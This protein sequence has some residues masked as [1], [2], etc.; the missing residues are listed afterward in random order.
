MDPSTR[1][2]LAQHCGASARTCER[3]QSLWSGYGAIWRCTLTDGRSVVLKSVQPPAGG[4]ISHRRK[5]RSYAVECRWYADFAPECDSA[6]RVPQVLALDPTPGAW[7]LL[8]ED[9]DAAGFSGRQHRSGAGS[10]DS[11]DA[12]VDWLAHFHATFMDRAPEGLWPEGS[13]WRLQTRPD[14]HAA[15]PAGPLKQA[16]AAIDARLCGARHR[17]LVHGDAKLANFCFGAQGVA[18]VD[19]QYVGGGCGMRDLAYL[20]SRGAHQRALDRYF[21]TLRSALQARH[22]AGDP[23]ALEAEWRALFPVAWADYCRFL[24]GWAPGW[25]AGDLDGAMIREALQGL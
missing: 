23:D 14:E 17:T 12:C 20:L 10:G 21:T 16:A 19:F 1:A 2:W 5:L 13:Y 22:W 15:M 9:L 6:C 4:G 8:L 25:R 7:R 18:A 3:I 24:E 11:L